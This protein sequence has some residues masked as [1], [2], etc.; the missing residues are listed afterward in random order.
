[1]RR[2]PISHRPREIEVSGLGLEQAFLAI[3]AG[4]G[5]GTAPESINGAAQPAPSY[6]RNGG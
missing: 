5:N 6:A 3:T 4:D 2:A 1:V